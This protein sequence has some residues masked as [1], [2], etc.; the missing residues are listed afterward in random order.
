MLLRP[1]GLKF[2]VGVLK[3]TH[4][5]VHFRVIDNLPV[6]TKFELEG[7]VM[8]VIKKHNNSSQNV[9]DRPRM[10][11]SFCLAFSVSYCNV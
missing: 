6:A 5:C 11:T 4:I 7:K 2:K 9:L 1:K 10:L 3:L 8:A